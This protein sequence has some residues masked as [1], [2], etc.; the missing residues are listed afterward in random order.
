MWPRGIAGTGVTGMYLQKSTPTLETE[1]NTSSL[2][3]LWL[4]PNHDLRQF[5]ALQGYFRFLTFIL[6]RIQF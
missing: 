2:L 3:R 4:Y 6:V 1:V 5:R